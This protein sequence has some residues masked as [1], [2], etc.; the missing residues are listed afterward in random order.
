MSNLEKIE[1]KRLEAV[2]KVN[3]ERTKGSIILIIGIILMIIGAISSLPVLI[4][5][6]LIVIFVGAYFLIKG[7]KYVSTFNDTVKTEIIN[8]LLHDEFENV[9]YLPHESID[10]M[11]IVKTDTVKK[12][13]RYNG[14]DYVSGIYKGVKFYTSDVNLLERIETTDGQGHR[15]VTYQSYFKGR[16]IVYKF[17]RTFQEGLKV[18]ESRNG[19][20]KRGF[21]K[22]ETESIEFNKK[23]TIYA[24]SKEYAFYQITSSMIEK[25]LEL[26][27]LHRGQILYCFMNN[28]LHIGIND[29]K[30]YLEISYKKPVTEEALSPIIADIEV[31][32]AIINEFRLDSSKF[33]ND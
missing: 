22:I 12:P 25:M 16:W 6:G 8:E 23:F 3:K 20:N 19:F 15:V 7:Q 28:E 18:I 9:N 30:D 13:D 2:K 11:D 33:K 1:Q 10:V 24:T 29:N 14:E 32:P 26:E 4:V 21:E 31:I 27:K 17:P 5:I